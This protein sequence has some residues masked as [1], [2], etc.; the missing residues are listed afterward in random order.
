MWSLAGHLETDL[1]DVISKSPGGKDTPPGAGQNPWQG[2]FAE[3]FSKAAAAAAAE[4]PPGPQ[5]QGGQNDADDLVLPLIGAGGAVLLAAEL[6]RREI[7]RR[8]SAG[9]TTGKGA[10]GEGEKEPSKPTSKSSEPPRDVQ[11]PREV[12]IETNG[13]KTKHL[14]LTERD[15]KLLLIPKGMNLDIK[16][17]DAPNGLKKAIGKTGEIPANYR[18]PGCKDITIDVLGQVK[19]HERYYL[20]ETARGP[21]VYHVQVLM[22]E[23]T[24][25]LLIEVHSPK[26][27]NPSE[28]V[29]PL[30]ELPPAGKSDPA[31]LRGPRD[32][33]SPYHRSDH[34]ALKDAPNE[35]F[36]VEGMHEGKLIIS[37]RGIGAE[38]PRVPEGLKLLRNGA[39]PDNYCPRGA[40][41][42][43]KQVLGQLQWDHRAYLFKSDGGYRLQFVRVVEQMGMHTAIAIEQPAQL[44]DPS[45]VKFDGATKV[46]HDAKTDFAIFS[47][48]T[49]S[50]SD[51]KTVELTPEQVKKITA[52]DGGEFRK[53]ELQMGSEKFVRYRRQ[54]DPPGRGTYY[55]LTIEPDGSAKMVE[56]T[57]IFERYCPA[58]GGTGTGAKLEPTGPKPPD[59]ETPDTK[60]PDPEQLTSRDRKDKVDKSKLDRGKV[61]GTGDVKMVLGKM[62]NATRA[63]FTE[64]EQNSVR[65]L[66]QFE[67]DFLKAM[68]EGEKRK[69]WEK[70]LSEAR[71]EAAVA[72]DAAR[73]QIAT[74]MAKARAAQANGRGGVGGKI[75]RFGVTGLSVAMVVD[76]LLDQA[77]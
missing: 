44:V 16:L 58:D 2:F 39:I 17:M 23:A 45:A 77:E 50:S 24:P 40:V 43:S 9:A 14:L 33:H 19:P 48:D 29:G 72:R 69:Q 1:M 52:G 66:A 27:V 47:K 28:V 56:D 60:K 12:T 26:Q 18:L 13:K 73:Q 71:G 22:D 10:E 32:P 68:P 5:P 67:E 31:A 37:K 49:P 55:T 4:S 74:V 21:R 30:P 61:E 35:P 7:A 11:Y 59:V 54:S 15:G 64:I 57:G 8:R 62:D 63:V 51:K 70:V 38:P 75:A 36:S 41:D 76:F 3:V 65:R 53:F 20:E 46:G 6:A 25:E 34:V 42:V